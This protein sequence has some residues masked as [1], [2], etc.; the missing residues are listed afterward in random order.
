MK[1]IDNEIRRV[2]KN[3]GWHYGEIELARIT[4]DKQMVLYCQKEIKLFVYGL[5]HS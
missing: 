3:I 1:M 4:G 5:R 2:S